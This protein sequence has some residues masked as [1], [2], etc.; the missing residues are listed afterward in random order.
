MNIAFTS[1]HTF[2]QVAS[3]NTVTVT[4]TSTGPVV[5]NGHAVLNGPV[6]G[7]MAGTYTVQSNG[8]GAMTLG[9]G[10]LIFQLAGSNSTG[11]R[12]TVIFSTSGGTNLG[13]GIAV[14]E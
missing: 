11:L 8:T 10:G 3:N 6:K 7:T 4:C 12:S 1:V 9:G 13:T 14:H 5:N 2:N